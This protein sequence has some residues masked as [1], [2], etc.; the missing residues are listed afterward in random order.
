MIKQF[1]EQLACYYNKENDL[2]N[3]VVAL[4]NTNHEFKEK[5]L[6]FF[7]PNININDI[8]G[9]IHREIPDKNNLSSRVDIHIPMR[10]E[11]MPYIIEVKINDKNHHF[12][13]YEEA[14]QIGKDRFGYITN[15]DCTEGKE[16]GYDVK[17]WEE[18][19]DYLNENKSEDELINAFTLYL[20]NVCG[21]TKY[22]K[23]MN[24]TGLESIPCFVDT[25]T[26]IIK[27]ERGWVKTEFYRECA[28]GSSVHEG[29]HIYFPGKD[30]SGFALYG[31]WFH[32]KPI[33]TICI[34][35]RS[36]LSE[37]IMNDR[38]NA[39]ENTQFSNKPYQERFWN[40]DDVWFELS[41]EKMQEFIDANSY[42]EQQAILENFFEEM[43][44]CIQKYF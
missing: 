39:I 25:V 2:S 40:K 20:K 14:Y 21:I 6:C 22:Y 7:F 4:C 23:P 5:F 16:S 41:D 26:K 11:K 8:D 19:Y 37:K 27:K 43:I 12:G 10:A 18:F 42:D 29:F 3:I 36:W 38:E 32:E 1:F 24:F 9:L 33:I 35:S 17:T 13:Q 31:L 44:G 28:Y 15:Y 30:N 34:N